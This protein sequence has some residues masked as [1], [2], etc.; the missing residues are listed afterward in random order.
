MTKRELV[1][2]AFR[3]EDLPYVPLGFWF[4]YTKDELVDGLV[5]PEMIAQNM[6]GHKK[7]YK[8]YQPDFVK[9]M[10]DGFFVYPSEVF[11]K[12][13]TAKELWQVS[14]IGNNH[15]WIEKQVAFVRELNDYFS[16]EIMTFYNIFSPATFFKFVRLKI[17]ENAERTLADFITE[18]ADAVKHAFSVAAGD[19]A[20]LTK[21]VINEGGCSGIYFSTQNVS[22]S[23]V[24]S[25][26]FSDIIAH[27]DK[28][29]LNAAANGMNILHICGYE[30]HKNNFYDFCDYPAQTVNWAAVFEGLSLQE[31]RKIFKGK[32][33]LGGF[34]NTVNGV[35][36]KG[37]RKEIEAA[38]EKILQETGTKGFIL[39]ADCTIPR[40]IDP[41]HIKWVRDYLQKR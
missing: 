38:T 12:A 8:E 29:V 20:T 23:R 32:T 13:K 10:S 40:D 30:G 31:G 37:S 39:G 4:H 16:G 15:E 6:E 25:S 1:Q 19:L 7:F 14:S 41:N 26:V 36:Y 34:D 18:D 11:C 24:Q 35:L 2:K 3:G 27:N 9:I 21:R 28:I 22:D 5:H 33:V 17:V